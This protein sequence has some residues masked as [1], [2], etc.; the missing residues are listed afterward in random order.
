MKNY[1]EF[2]KE[3]IDLK[4][5]KG[6]PSDF[7]SSAEKQA[8]A[9]LNIRI[10]DPSQMQRYGGQ[11]MQLVGQS[12]SIVRSGLNK[13][14]LEERFVKLEKLATDIVLSEYGEILEAS[15]KPVDLIIKLLRPRKQVKS[16]I[17]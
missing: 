1:S 15:D 6:I 9:N 14:E 5:N 8:K 3:E 12:D 4:G 7:M 10:D 17:I 16:E 2:L 13:D 11:L